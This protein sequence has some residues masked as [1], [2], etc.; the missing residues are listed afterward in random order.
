MQ[1]LIEELSDLKGKRIA[2]VGLGRSGVSLVRL[3]SELGS[4]LVVNDIKDLEEIKKSL[5]N[6]VERVDKIFPERHI[7]QALE[8]IDMV[9]VS[10]GVPL[11]TPSIV[12]AI[13]KGIPVVGEIELS[14][15]I[16]NLVNN[17]IK[18]IGI[19]GSNGKSTTS[20]LTYEFLKRD[21][22]KVRLAG[23]IGLPMA[24]VVFD[25]LKGTVEIDYLVLELSSFQLEGIKNFKVNYGAI[26]NITPDHMDRYSGMREYIRA[27]AKIFQNMDQDD[28][29]VLNMDDKN[30]IATI[31]LLRDVYLKRGKLPHILYFSRLQKKVYGAYL[32]NLLVK[33]NAREELSESIIKEFENTV[34][35]ID[36]FRI[37][38]V[39]NIENIM[40][41]SL[42]ALLAGV[43]GESIRSVVQEFPGLPHRM[44]FVREIDGISFFNDSKGTNIDAVKKSLES[45]SGNVIL[46]AGGR[47]KDGDFTALRELVRN[48]V[49]ALILIGEAKEKI[50]KALSD[51]VPTYF[52]LDMESAVRKAKELATKGDVVLLSPGCASFDMYRNFEHRGDNFKEIV[53]SL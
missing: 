5:D 30:T 1:R 39:H 33:F 2:I 52:E 51:L 29:L 20:T 18:I 50:A 35:P 53:N 36:S 47:D 7:P 19:T 44:E 48:K 10:P 46:I 6:L 23:N 28:F 17:K 31:E 3:L 15:Q 49:K 34:L 41:S 13:Y 21:D 25:V 42:L 37:K 27:K 14:W 26:L 38:G 16:L 45:F 43:K 8:E 24:E 12:S 9:V 4:R 22:K 32:D 40:A 11:S